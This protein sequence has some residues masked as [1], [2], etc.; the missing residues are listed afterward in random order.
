MRFLADECCDG[1]VVRALRD[2]GHDVFSVAES[3]PGA[4]DDALLALAF[5]EERLVLTEDRDFGELVH[6]LRLP[7][8]GVVYL[9]FGVEDRAEK[10]PRLVEVVDTLAERLP[11]AFVVLEKDRVRLRPLAR[12]VQAGS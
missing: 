8:H 12:N 11:G 9:R 7:S 2:H 1:G 4:S 5:E 3:L 10:A 6:R